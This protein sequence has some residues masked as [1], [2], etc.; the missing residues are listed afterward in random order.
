MIL[1]DVETT[2]IGPL[3]RICQIAIKHLESGE[4]FCELFKPPVPIGIEAMSVTHITN[5][6]VEDKP[7]FIGSELFKKLQNDDIVVAH[8]AKFDISLLNK[9]GIYPKNVICT[10]KLAHN[11]DEAGELGKHNLQYLRYFY[12]LKIDGDVVAHDALGDVIVLEQLY[13]FYTQ[14]YSVEE[15]LQLTKRP[16]LLKVFPFGKYKGEKFS[17]VIKIDR[18]YFNWLIKNIT[19]MSEDLEFTINYYLNHD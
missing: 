12:K 15:M 10:M 8:N 5:E 4:T 6:D 11:F 3:D 18:N 2:G 1:L 14:K 16:I 17:Y 9:E 19:D 13:N 7:A